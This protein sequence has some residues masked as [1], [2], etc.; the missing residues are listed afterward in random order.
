MLE[1]QGGL[2]LKSGQGS[3][4]P[5]N[6]IGLGYFLP[7]RPLAGKHRLGQAGFNALGGQPGPLAFR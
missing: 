5:N 2:P 3:I 7:D 6:V 4:V 1:E